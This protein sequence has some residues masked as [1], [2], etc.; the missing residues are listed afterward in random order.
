MN[1]NKKKFF[2]T[3]AVHSRQIIFYTHTRGAANSINGDMIV[4]VNNGISEWHAEITKK[5]LWYKNLYINISN[6]ELKNKYKKWKI[7][8]RSYDENFYKLATRTRGDCLKNWKWLDIIDKAFWLD[9]YPIEILDPFADEIEL[10]ILNAMKKAKLDNKFLYEL[11]SPAE[12]TLTQ[13]IALEKNKIKTPSD[14]RKFL[15][16][17]WFSGGTWNGGAI[18]SRD[19]LRESKKEKPIKSIFDNRKKTQFNLD[20]KLDYKTRNLI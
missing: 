5:V 17:Y 9:S 16:K 18:L 7:R 11:I 12:P 6:K 3:G 4:L 8:W 2:L 19:L 13:K 15:R 10:M 20:R 14:E 1:L